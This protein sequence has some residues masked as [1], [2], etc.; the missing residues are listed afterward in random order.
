MASG[1]GGIDI[2]SL[3]SGMGPAE[4]TLGPVC[5]IVHPH[6]AAVLNKGITIYNTTNFDA[7]PIVEM[8]EPW[9]NML[10]A[11]FWVNY[12]IHGPPQPKIT[13]FCS[14]RPRDPQNRIP[15]VRFMKI[16]PGGRS[17]DLNRTDLRPHLGLANVC[18]SLPSLEVGPLEVAGL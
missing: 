6:I 15:R 8:L 13:Q 14:P 7:A 5:R 17:G 2:L 4:N 1:S 18:S 9:D 16:R 12:S 10:K 3:A 11:Y